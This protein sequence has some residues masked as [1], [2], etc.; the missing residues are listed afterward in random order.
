[1][2][3]NSC[4]VALGQKENE[5]IAENKKRIKEINE[6]ITLFYEHDLDL[7]GIHRRELNKERNRLQR[8][9]NYIRKGYIKYT[10][11]GR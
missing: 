1:M 6:R 7:A 10:V 11:E 8:E 2:L 4:Y 3:S 5:I 9:N